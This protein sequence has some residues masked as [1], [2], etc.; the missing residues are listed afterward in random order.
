MI[1]KSEGGNGNG[2]SCVFP[3]KYNGV[4][5]YQCTY[6]DRDKFNNKKWCCVNSDCDDKLEW[7]N[8]P[9]NN[10]KVFNTFYHIIWSFLLFLLIKATKEENNGCNKENYQSIDNGNNC[11]KLVSKNPKNWQDAS[12]FCKSEGGN[13]VSIRD[14]FEQA[15]VSLIKTSSINAE[16]IGLQKVL[17]YVYIYVNIKNLHKK[18]FFKKKNDSVQFYWSDN[19]PLTYTNWDK[20]W[21]GT[22]TGSDAKCAFLNRFDSFW[23][24]SSCDTLNDFICKISNGRLVY[25][26]ELRNTF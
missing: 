21:I 8:C 19:N 9:S 14:P 6:E 17:T 4:Q 7:G 24:S 12:D 3:F 20:N 10:F 2:S 16:W 26:R 23:N 25:L 5:H 13:L 22:D 18:T 15:Y 11:Y 1:V